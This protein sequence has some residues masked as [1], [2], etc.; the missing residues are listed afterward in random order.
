MLTEAQIAKVWS[1]MLAAEARSYY[2]GDLAARYVKVKQWIT[3]I[4]FFLSSG[5]AATIVGKAPSWV[6]IS[7][8]IVVAAASAYAMAIN[9]DG[10]ISTMAKLQ[11]AWHRIMVEYER[12]WNHPD[13]PDAE[14]KLMRI[15]QME[16]DPS[17]QATTSAPN[18][19]KLL[20]KWQKRVFALRGLTDKHA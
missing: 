12:L 13:A 6:P 8:S 5:A 18:D 15:I 4:S 9:L 16:E 10:N 2:F 17:E 19:Q 20:A 7:L 11:L 1:D 3:G 14:D